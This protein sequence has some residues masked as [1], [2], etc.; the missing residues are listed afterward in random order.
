MTGFKSFGDRTVT[1]RLSSGFTCIVG[2]NGAGKSNIIDALCFALGRLSKKTMRAKSLEDLI[3]AGSRGKNPSQRASVTLFFD[4]SDK[5]FPGEGEDFQITRVVKRGGGGGYKMNGKKVT[6]QQILNA[7]AAANI[8]PDGSNQFVLQGK[9]VE[10]THMNPEDRRVFIEELIGL[11][12]YDEMKDVT[13][14]ELEKAERDLGQFEAIFKE[15]SSQLKKVE[16]EKN[17]ALAWKEL[18]EK[19]NFYNSQLIAL[20]ISLL[21]KEEADLEVKIENSNKIIEE[22]NEKVTRQEELLKQE[23]LV[24]DNIQKTIT[25][26]EKERETINENITQLK[27]QLSSNQTTLNLAQKSIEKLQNE[28]MELEKLQ[29]EL[30]EGQTYDSLIE[31]VSTEITGIEYNIEEAKKEIESKQQVQSELDAK[32]KDSEDEKSS[33]KAEISGIKQ[34]ISS[35]NAQISLLKENMKKNEEKKQKLEADLQKLKGEAESI[36][37]AIKATKEEETSIRTTIA[38]LNANI[39]DENKKQQ[40]LENKIAETRGEKAQLNE[41]IGN[42]QSSLSSLNTEIKLSNDRIQ[43]LTARKTSIEKKIQDLSKG[44]D[45]EEALKELLKE[46]DQ[47]LKELNELKAKA[48]QEDSAFR[49][50]EQDLELLLMKQDSIEAEIVDNKAKIENLNTRLKL[51]EKELKSLDRDKRDLELT[52]S[53]ASSNLSQTEKELDTLNAKKENITRRIEELNKEK[54]NLLQKIEATEQE[55]ERNTEDVTGILQILN[56]LTQNINISVESIKSNIQQSNAEAIETSADDFRKFVL[57]IID[58][59]KTVEDVEKEHEVQTEH[60]EQPEHGTSLKSILQTLAL[61]TENVDSTIDQLISKVKESADVEIQESTSTF[62]TFVQDL[63]E[64]L[65]NVYLSLRKLTMS[66][67][68]E[69]YKQLEEIST[70]INS[71]ADDLNGVGM[72][73]KEINIQNSHDSETLKVSSKKLEE[74]KGRIQELETN[75]DEYEKEVT[76]RTESINQKQ[77]EDLTEEIKKLKDLKETYWENNSELEAKIDAKQKEFD[78]IQTK[79]QE[80]RGIENLVENMM[81]IDNNVQQLNKT[82]AEKKAVIVDTE[83]QIAKIKEDQDAFDAKIEELNQEKNKF[84]ENTEKIRAQIDDETKKLEE[85]MDKLRSLE[86]IMMIISS[87]EELTKENEEAKVSIESNSKEIEEADLK[88]SEIQQSVDKVQEVIDGLRDEKVKEVE[89][90]K[91]A[92]SS[93]NKLNK[94]LQK[95]QKKLNELNKNKERELKIVSLKEDI[96]DTEKEVEGISTQIESNNKEL[97]AENEKKKEK[98]EEIDKYVTEKDESWKKQKGYQKALNEL[99]SDHSM[100]RS[101]LASYESKKIICTDQ[102]ET[103]YQRSKDYGALPPVTDELSEAGLQSDIATANNKKKA[104]EPV[105]LKAIEQFDIVKERFDEIDMRRQTI[106]RERKSILDAIEKIELE[107]TRT[108]MKAYHEINREFSR[109]F[110]KLSPGGSAKMILDR[111]DK[112]FEGGVSIEARPRGKKISSLEIL[113]GGEKT[114]VALSFIFAVQEFYPAPFFVLDE[115]DAALDGPNVHRVSMAIK[116]FSQQAQFMVISHREENIV[117]S[118]RIY[119]VSMQQS[120]ITDIFSV[121][122]EEEAK[123]IL[124]LPDVVETD[125]E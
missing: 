105:N 115:I 81:E 58:I 57:D 113:S 65:E 25:E 54:D 116:E 77:A 27:T 68:Q 89:A 74:I 93:L 37:E 100:E 30:E 124:E 34:T 66:K 53:S 62:D 17:D 46:K 28:I 20:K 50:N 29:M 106:Q 120:G 122:L 55:Y 14:K 104:L 123:R 6:R 8:D 12:K 70:T 73:I 103:L 61:F 92:Q 125:V 9:I 15:V 22:L 112:P 121:D 99:K 107:K 110:Q 3:F 67:S 94:D 43:S 13:M 87:I 23:S 56:M 84:W 44:K 2:P 47:I 19:I 63:M 86:N 101:K 35:K 51:N 60:E 1:I 76:T 97:E 41:K 96:T 114:L 38:E 21:R 111:P 36:D 52:V 108:F 49:K 59:M 16:K 98:Q 64:I 80:L 42:F 33:F 5:E 40:D 71:Q 88:V 91:K 118:D 119:G 82:I 4:N 24:M 11:Q 45:S 32:I 31:N 75:S 7:L 109:I 90:Q 48:K 39:S 85:T 78:V 95:V 83:G 79:L 69:L 117:N 102:I 26:K 10:L 18:D 72:H